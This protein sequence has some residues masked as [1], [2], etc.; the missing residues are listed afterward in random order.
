[1]EG[2]QQLINRRAEDRLDK[3]ITELRRLLR[4]NSLIQ[5]SDLQL[6]YKDISNTLYTM[7]HYANDSFF[8]D[9]RKELLPM[10]LHEESEAFL[11]EFDQLKDRFQAL[12]GQVDNL[13]QQY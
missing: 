12:Q 4:S 8:T 11:K 2:I 7:S 3:D 9:L 6:K 5:K 1:M 13:P 10:Y